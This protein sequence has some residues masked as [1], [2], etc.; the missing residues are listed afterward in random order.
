ML[1]S[2]F[3]A[4]LLTVLGLVPSHAQLLVSASGGGASALTFTIHEQVTFESTLTENGVSTI[5]LVIEDA[6]TTNQADQTTDSPF[7]TTDASFSVPVDSATFGIADRAGVF[8]FAFGS[9][10]FFLSFD[11]AEN[12]EYSVGDDIVLNPGI[13]TVGTGNGEFYNLPDNL[14]NATLRLYAFDGGIQQTSGS[15]ANAIPEPATAGLLLLGGAALY[16]RRRPRR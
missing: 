15:I 9:R 13:F 7:V 11:S 4:L 12:A 2:L 8:N 16:L 6:Y 1:R 3:A 14:T 5:F 10:A